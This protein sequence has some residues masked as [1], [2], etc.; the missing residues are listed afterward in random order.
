MH[1][2]FSES[3]LDQIYQDSVCK[4]D[5]ANP[6]MMN[7]RHCSLNPIEFLLVQGKI[8]LVPHICLTFN[9]IYI[10]EIT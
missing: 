4:H 3:L 6:A 2:C 7:Q 10:A 1:S 8:S 5:G 9:V